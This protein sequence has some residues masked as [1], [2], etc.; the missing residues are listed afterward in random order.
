M[1]WL[2]FFFL[3]FLCA[4]SG[5]WSNLSKFCLIHTVQFEISVSIATEIEPGDPEDIGPDAPQGTAPP[6]ETPDLPEV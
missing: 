5:Q 2:D 3:V 6:T 4:S 1:K